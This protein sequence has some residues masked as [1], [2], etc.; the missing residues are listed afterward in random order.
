MTDV[1]I[2]KIYTIDLPPYHDWESYWI[3]PLKIST[4]HSWGGTYVCQVIGISKFATSSHTYTWTADISLED[5]K[6]VDSSMT[7]AKF[8]C[9]YQAYSSVGND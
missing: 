9:I 4:S 6:L 3:L 1:V 5:Y 8:D 2:G 7:Q